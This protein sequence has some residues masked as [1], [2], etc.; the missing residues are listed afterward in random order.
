[1]ENKEQE[2]AF[3]PD[4]RDAFTKVTQFLAEANLPIEL[5]YENKKPK[6]L[7]ESISNAWDTVQAFYEQQ[8]KR[9][10]ETGDIVL[11]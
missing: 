2:I 9:E 10:E 1:M 3:E 7:P 6:N 8:K 11:L 5:V 4:F